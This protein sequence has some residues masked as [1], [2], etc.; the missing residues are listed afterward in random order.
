M[1]VSGSVDYLCNGLE[2]RVPSGCF[3]L[4]FNLSFF[5]NL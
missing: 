3:L 5:Y 1:F 2:A 4:G